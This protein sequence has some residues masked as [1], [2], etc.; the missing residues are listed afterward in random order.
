METIKLELTEQEI[1]NL[2]AVLNKVNITGA[3]ALPVAQLQVKLAN[4][5]PK[6][7]E[8]KKK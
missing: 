6:E 8:E 3:E 1:T 7:K 4:T 5:L 2:L